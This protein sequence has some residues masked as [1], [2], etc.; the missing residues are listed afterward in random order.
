M[1][2]KRKKY[3]KNLTDVRF[4]IKLNQLKLPNLGRVDN[5]ERICKSNLSW[6]EKIEWAKRIS[7]Y[8]GSRQET[9]EYYTVL[10]NCKNKAKEKIKE[11][12]KKMMGE[13]NTWYN[14]GG[15][16]S[17][18][19]EGSVNYNP[20]LIKDIHDKLTSEGNYT[21]KVEYY[22][23]KGYSK[24]EAEKMRSERQAVGRLDKFVERYGKEDGRKKWQERQ[25]KWQETL[26]NKSDEEKARINSLKCCKGHSVSR[27]EKELYTI[28]NEKISL[29]E[30]AKAIGYNNNKN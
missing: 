11:K 9:V 30:M 3:I 5:I 16:Y 28:L 7:E 12:S 24:E 17:P 26:N 1:L 4:F 13:K 2:T 29:L 27:G 21:T 15:K 10:Y 23:N 20:N 18:F 25:I 8:S 14:H 19:K 22:L 6:Q